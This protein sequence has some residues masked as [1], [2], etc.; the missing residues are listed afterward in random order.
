MTLRRWAPALTLCMALVSAALPRAERSSAADLEKT[1]EAVQRIVELQRNLGTGK[2]SLAQ[3]HASLTAAKRAELAPHDDAESGAAGEAVASATEAWWGAAASVS[4]LEFEK[5]KQLATLELTHFKAIDGAAGEA[6]R[7]AEE[8]EL[9]RRVAATRGD[10]VADESVVRSAENFLARREVLKL[11][12]TARRIRIETIAEALS[13]ASTA[14]GSASEL[15]ALKR[16]ERA[17]LHQAVLLLGRAAN[18]A[19]WGS[20]GVATFIDSVE[21]ELG[22]GA[23][24]DGGPPFVASG[25]RSSEDG[26]ET[27]RAAPTTKG[28]LHGESLASLKAELYRG[29]P[30]LPPARKE[31]SPR[32]PSTGAGL[33]GAAQERVSS[34]SP[35]A[36]PVSVQSPPPVP[37]WSSAQCAALTAAPP[38]TI[39]ALRRAHRDG[40]GA[41]AASSPPSSSWD[42]ADRDE[43]ED[44]DENKGSDGR[45]AARPLFEPAMLPGASTNNR[46]QMNELAFV[47]S[48]L[49]GRSFLLDRRTNSDFWTYDR[50]DFERAVAVVDVETLAL[51][52]AERTAQRRDA[53]PVEGLGGATRDEGVRSR[54]LPQWARLLGEEKYTR[55][56]VLTTN[57]AWG[58]PLWILRL[59]R[60]LLSDPDPGPARGAPPA[61]DAGAQADSQADAQVSVLLCTVTFYAN[62]AHNLTRAP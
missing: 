46:R 7:V 14:A 21:Q 34:T 28:T 24:G 42:E 38:P 40:A 61:P 57:G 59:A 12:R 44:E 11:R 25:M 33:R 54:T 13:T 27:G 3:A 6:E 16:E 22:D 56:S 1:A 43:D 55:A 50:A 53:V 26:G 32:N 2:H 15:N 20:G 8:A 30:L 19:A 39:V 10:S 9:L 29:F 37:W 48:Y 5:Q 51:S 41:S 23:L 45:G 60:S 52:S 49:T 62:L 36:S 58:S 17:E 35:A 47:A 31:A 18:A 4:E